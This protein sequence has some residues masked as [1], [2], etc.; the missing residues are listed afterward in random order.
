VSIDLDIAPMRAARVT[1]S[2]LLGAWRQRLGNEAAALLGSDPKLRVLGAGTPVAGDAALEL[3]GHYSLDMAAPNTLSLSAMPSRNNLDEVEYLE[4]FARNLEPRETTA[5]ALSWREVGHYYEV[6]SGGGRSPSE[7]A[8]LITLAC[9]LAGICD[10]RIIVMNDGVFDLGIGVY[11][12][13]Q[14]AAARWL[15]TGPVPDRGP[16]S[17]P[18]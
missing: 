9:A 5:L 7:P 15:R 2:P 6:S 12:A 8:L 16:S 11:T 18:P 14:F 3:P 17:A 13:E 1:W 10:G 4:D